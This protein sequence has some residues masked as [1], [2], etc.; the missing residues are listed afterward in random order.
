MPRCSWTRSLQGLCC[1]APLHPGVSESVVVL[2]GGPA[3]MAE[4]CALLL[5]S[6]LWIMLLQSFALCFVDERHFILSSF[7]TLY[8]WQVSVASCGLDT[9]FWGQESERLTYCWVHWPVFCLLW[10]RALKRVCLTGNLSTFM[11]AVLRFW[12]MKLK[13]SFNFCFL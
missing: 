3:C 11:C 13:F 9:V 10:G 8:I 12:R 6:K 1:Q 7:W 2:G 5:H 4:M